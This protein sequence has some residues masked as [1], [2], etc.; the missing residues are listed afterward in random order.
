MGSSGDDDRVAFLYPENR[1]DVN[2]VDGYMEYTELQVKLPALPHGASWRRR[3]KKGLQQQFME[4]IAISHVKGQSVH[5]KDIG[6]EEIV[7]QYKREFSHYQKLLSVY[8]LP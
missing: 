6:A 2:W 3:L 7:D 4:A 5:L 1:K 8:H